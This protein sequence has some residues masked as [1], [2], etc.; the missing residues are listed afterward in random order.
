MTQERLKNATHVI[1]RWD[2]VFKALAAEP[3][4]Q[5]IVSLSDESPDTAVEL[6]ENAMNPNVPVDFETLERDL[7]HR[8]LPLLAKAEL[9]EWESEPLR[10]RRGPKFEEAA[11]VI[12]SLQSSPREIPDSLVVGCQ[13]LEAERQRQYEQ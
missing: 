1:E 4:R 9:V 5:I 10:A 3:R 8:H 2:T 7:H 13:R 6:P 11:I 12:E